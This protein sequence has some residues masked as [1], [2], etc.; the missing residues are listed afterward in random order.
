MFHR[1]TLLIAG[2]AGAGLLLAPPAVAGEMPSRA[3]GL[4]QTHDVEVSDQRRKRQR[5]VR[6]G[7]GQQIAC[8][9]WGCRPIP[10]NCR[11]TTEYDFFGNPSGFDAVVCR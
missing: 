7:G 6:R 5:A 1:T 2:L 3:P 4:H 10:R 8:T 9:R 11:I